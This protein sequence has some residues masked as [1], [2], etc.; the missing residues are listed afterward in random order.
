[1]QQGGKASLARIAI[2]A[3]LVL[4]GCYVGA[5]LDTWLVF[6]GVGA[7]ILFLPY[8]IVTAALL[9]TPRRY[10]WIVFLAATAGDV[11]PHYLGG[12]SIAFALLAELINDGRS[13][14]AA[15]GFSRFCRSGRVQTMREMIAFLAIIV[16]VAPWL[17][18]LAGAWLVTSSSGVGTFALVWREWCLSSS[19]A[20]LTLLPML[21][22]ELRTPTRRRAEAALLA[23]LLLA[24]GAYVFAS[25]YDES[26]THQAHMYWALPF[27]LWAAIRFGLRGTSFA[28]FAVTALSTWGA[29]TGRGPFAA[30]QPAGN[31]I[32]L[33]VFLLAV[34][35]PALLLAVLTEQQR[36][37]AAEL[38]ESRRQYRSIV[39]DQTEMI[40]R[41]RPD[42]TY[43]FANRAYCETF[44][45]T[46]DELRTGLVWS[47]VPSQVHPSRAYLELFT[48]SAPIATREV[49][50]ATRHGARWQ[51]WGVRAFF[52]E[53]GIAVEYQAV[54]R[55]ITDRKRA[56]D[57][58]AE[59][60]ARKSVEAVLRDSDRRK[61]E[62]LA[63]LGHE[64]RNPLAPIGIALELLLEA[65]PGSDD[66]EWARDSIKRQ[67]GQMTRLLD[68]LLD[69]SR[70]TLGKIEL[71][72]EP[73]DLGRV[74]ANA[75]EASRP[76]VESLDHDLTIELP[77]DRVMVRGDA[78]RLAQVVQNLV[79]NAAK[80]TDRGGRIEV[81]VT[82]EA[83]G[84]RLAV[85]DNGIGLAP[86][87]LAKIFDQFTQLPA[88]RERAAGGLGIGL[89]LVRKLVELHGGSVEA[90]SAGPMLGSELVVNLPAVAQDAVEQAM[91]A[92]RAIES[93][94]LR[95]LAVDDNIDI[96]DGLEAV[97][98]LWGHTVRTANDGVAALEVA[99]AFA[100]DVVL[101][102]LGLP[103]IDGLE[104]ARRLRREPEHSTALLVS[105]SGFGHQQTHQR[106][107]EA[108]FHHHLVKPIDLDSLRSLLD[109]SMRSRSAR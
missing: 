28:I 102:D 71:K 2:T 105:M 32:E 91:P 64:L 38:T 45:Q 15:V 94:A 68:D 67:L 18:A 84:I 30:G 61:D 17:G 19:I 107:D 26:H 3:A 76:L 11:L 43:T 16:L 109:D 21:V 5:R 51:H 108:G 90:S 4:A 83:S 33:E 9:R 62:F 37:T 95:I 52:D 6:P 100:P 79:N 82:R 23:V 22:L 29:L 92:P 70:I 7:A 39:E 34:S 77:E 104:V 78:G 59:L 57:E 93:R 14:I 96:A 46:C 106:S 85:R 53:S 63:I 74:I 72:L 103:R 31:V 88:G 36:R 8:A 86:D 69:I 20:A 55:D 97:L 40:C 54:G 73:V 60:Q 42:G 25:G 1:M 12:K 49:V 75:V 66:A 50:V 80:Y 24:I 35:I 101:L 10:W 87:S 98:K 58:H 47:S 89:S 56:E 81:R 44:G 65:P 99:S 41:F 27:L 48:A 13:L